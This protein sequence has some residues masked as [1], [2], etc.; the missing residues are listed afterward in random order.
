MSTAA[1]AEG[2]QLR[3]ID[4]VALQN[5][6][7]KDGLVAVYDVMCLVTGQDLACCSKMWDRLTT[8]HP[9]LLAVCQQVRFK[10]TGRGSNQRRP[11][12][13]ARPRCRPV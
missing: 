12:G 13:A 3:A 9:E 6:R 10:S 5:V 1:G 11:A 8:S 2:L 7:K 4:L